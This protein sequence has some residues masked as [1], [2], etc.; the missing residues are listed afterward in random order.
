MKKNRTKTIR[1]VAL[2]T[3]LAMCFQMTAFAQEGPADYLTELKNRIAA[4][5]EQGRNARITKEDGINALPLEI[6]QLAAAENVTLEMEYTYEGVEYMVDI[7]GAGTIVDVNVPICGPLYLAGVYGKWHTV[8]KGD[9]LSALAKT[10]KTT[11]A[12]IKALNP[13]IK[14][15]DKI[16]YG[17]R[18]RVR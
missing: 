5:K 16:Y 17:R 10:Y 18:I 12:N 8:K 9:T 1:T 2:S 15:A 7:P 14:D 6:I 3:A 11:V 4:A 13:E